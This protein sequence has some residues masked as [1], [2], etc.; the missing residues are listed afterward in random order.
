[1][2]L[3]MYQGR[4]E[5]V[6]R[7]AARFQSMLERIPTYDE[8]EVKELFVYGLHKKTVPLMCLQN[9]NA[10]LEEVIL[11]AE[12]IEM[13][14][15]YCRENRGRQERLPQEHSVEDQY[16]QEEQSSQ[17]L[18]EDAVAAQ[19]SEPAVSGSK[20]RR[21]RGGRRGRAHKA[22]KRQQWE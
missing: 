14:Q 15:N 2:L 20:R 11:K 12:E 21:H 16:E 4:Q 22:W 9:Q 1:M 17:E 10:A 5:T 19:D 6:R 7:Y 3:G 8:E 18:Y 13:V